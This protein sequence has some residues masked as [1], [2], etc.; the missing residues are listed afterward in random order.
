[1]L[2]VLSTEDE[3]GMRFGAAET[4]EHR[5]GSPAAPG[6]ETKYYT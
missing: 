4:A 1:M 6:I 3:C 2:G 5:S